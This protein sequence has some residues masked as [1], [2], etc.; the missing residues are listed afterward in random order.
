MKL[1]D[2]LISSSKSLYL[3]ELQYKRVFVFS[4]LKSLLFFFMIKT[5]VDNT[6]IVLIL[7]SLFSAIG[8]AYPVYIKSKNKKNVQE[9]WEYTITC[10]D[11]NQSKELSDT[12]RNE[13]ITILTS[14]GY[15]ESI[16]KILIV[17]AISKNSSSG[18]IIENCIPSG[19]IVS[20]REGIRSY[21]KK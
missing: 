2:S 10:K 5:T 6:A 4:L 15:S 14:E 7:A 20:V 8:S 21:I 19:C 9:I 1:A 13:G 18:K 17:T 3:H 11:R 12:L 16:D